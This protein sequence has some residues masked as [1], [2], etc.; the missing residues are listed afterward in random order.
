MPRFSIL[1]FLFFLKFVLSAQNQCFDDFQDQDL[2]QQVLWQGDTSHFIVNS[3]RQLQLNQPTAGSSVLWTQLPVFNSDSLGIEFWLRENFSP[4]SLNYG[5]FYLFADSTDLHNATNALFLQFGESGSSDAIRLFK[6]HQGTDSLIGA[7]PLGDIAAPFSRAIRFL[8]VNGTFQLWSSST[9][10][11]STALLFEGSLNISNI[12]SFAG[13]SL[14]YTAANA[15]AFYFDD[16]YFG[17]ALS[18]QNKNLI[19]TEIMADPDTLFGLPASEYIEVFNAGTELVQLKGLKLQDGNTTCTL[20]SYWLKPETYTVLVG[21]NQSN[22]FNLEN[23]LEVSAFVSLNNSG[24]WLRLL[25]PENNIIDQ[26]NY[27][28]SWY[29]DSLPLTDGISLE[30][31]SLM[32]PCSSK[33]NWGASQGLLGGTPGA[34]NSINDTLPDVVKPTLLEANVLDEHYL[35][36][37]FSEP[38]DTTTLANTDLLIEPDLG[39]FERL[40][41]AYENSVNEAQ[42]LLV[43]GPE[44][45]NSAPF[46][47]QLEAVADCWMNFTTLAANA[48]RYEAPLVGD[49]VINELL[50]DPPNS[51]EDFVE[52]YNRSQKYLDLSA[53]G[54]HN[55][56]DSI[57]LTACKMAPQQFLALG[58]DTHFL[59]DYYPY[60]KAE[61]LVEKS[62]PYFYNDS[63]T[64]VLFSNAS[65]LDSL[66]YSASWHFPFL[67]DSE[68]Y[69][70]ERIN[71]N[72]PTQTP[73]NWFSG[74]ASY[75]GATPG[76]ANSQQSS[77][78]PAGD[79][80]LNFPELSP[81]L[82]GYHDRLEV[83]YQMSDPGLFACASIF[84]LDGQKLKDLLINES[85]GT[86]GQFF[87]DGTTQFGTLAPAGIYVLYFQAFST[88]PGVFFEKKILFSVCYKA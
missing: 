74:A 69:S 55:C 82:D 80:S 62:L 6:R 85:I 7:G 72:T 26:V 28:A 9:S 41:F 36:L 46:H 73:E 70:L 65:V 67:P 81:D 49:L 1:L 77:A 33:D 75:G 76:R 79:L 22:G 66:H 58:S 37:R 18:H 29:P 42:C 17:K 8:Y 64:C 35:S 38:I 56:Q 83:N 13:L 51:G 50:F 88:N 5:Y 84:T 12:G 21:T 40:V 48:I 54:F 30:R 87:W 3:A 39:S 60:A 11:S 86:S 45:P 43:F 19:L 47:I 16:F 34:T 24:E 20:P 44:I 27:S 59:T 68:G 14:V 61:N 15:D 78:N 52:L 23:I 4:S 71:V 57:F 32:D 63:G 10:A 2:S 53:C 31:Q 25:T